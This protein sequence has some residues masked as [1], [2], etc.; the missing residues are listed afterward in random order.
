[1]IS[2]SASPTLAINT[3]T[4][5]VL[6][7]A[8]QPPA[9]THTWLHGCTL[10]PPTFPTTYSTIPNRESS[11]LLKVGGWAAHTTPHVHMPKASLQC[12]PHPNA[13]QSAVHHLFPQQKLTAGSCFQHGNMMLTLIHGI[14]QP[15]RPYT[16]TLARGNTTS[17]TGLLHF[18]L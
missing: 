18:H 16:C 2:G 7:L 10:T 12:N 9:P 5:K 11:T 3:V 14:L 15:D 13:H 17:R 1:M 8:I 6:Q 4:N